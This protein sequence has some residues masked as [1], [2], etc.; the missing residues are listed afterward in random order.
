MEGI[1][2][3]PAFHPAGYVRAASALP[4]LLLPL[5]KLCVLLWLMV[6]GV[7]RCCTCCCFCYLLRL[8]MVV[9]YA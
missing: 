4:L 3:P 2:A 5:L 1:I 9:S 6:E 7:V 8:M